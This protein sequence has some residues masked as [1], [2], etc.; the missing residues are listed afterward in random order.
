[1]GRALKDTEIKVPGAVGPVSKGMPLSQF[2][3]KGGAFNALRGRPM[4][5]NMKTPGFKS[6]MKKGI[7]S[8]KLQNPALPQGNL[9]SRS[10]SFSP[11][12]KKY[13]QMVAGGNSGSM[14][15]PPPPGHPPS[16]KLPM[17]GR[18]L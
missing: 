7:D 8:G 17:G 5:K 16:T 13:E 12:S 18:R 11:F 4:D 3:G 10:K 15:P 9:F 6:L 14:T 1:M 2:A